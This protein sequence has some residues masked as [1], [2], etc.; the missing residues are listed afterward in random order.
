MNKAIEQFRLNI[1]SAQILDS[2]YNSFDS[3]VNIDLSE[4][5][6]AEL[7]LTVSALDCFIHDIVRL[8]TIEIYNGNKRAHKDLLKPRF[9]IDKLNNLLT[10]T[11]YEQLTILENEFREING[12][13]TFQKPD[14]IAEIIKCLGIESLWENISIEIGIIQEDIENR[15]Q[16]IV[17]RRD[18]IVHEADIDY[19]QINIMK[20]S[21]E[22]QSV[23][24]DIKLISDVCEA[25]YKLANSSN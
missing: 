21:I 18:K 8:G 16:L 22:H 4:I 23:L 25:I 24:D 1:K 20:N 7:V 15:I 14:K 9:P 17:E 11:K 13:K 6:R 10:K 19:Q 5:L 2:I 3:N 12:T